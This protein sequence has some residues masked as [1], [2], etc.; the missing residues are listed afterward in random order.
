MRRVHGVLMLRAGSALCANSPIFMEFF[1]TVGHFRYHG[2]VN[3]AS[4]AT[5]GER[6][7]LKRAAHDQ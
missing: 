6:A 5:L 4:R 3:F 2:A 7:V 1:V